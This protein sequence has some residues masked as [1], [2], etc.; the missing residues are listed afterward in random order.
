MAE[1]E[2]ESLAVDYSH[3]WQVMTAVGVAV[4]LGT[5]DGSIVNIAL[6]TI[7]D[8]FGTSFGVIQWVPLSYLLVQATLVLGMGRLGDIAGR[9]TMFITGFAIFTVGSVL[10]GLSPTVLWLI[11][12][13]VVQGI[14]SA[15]IFSM[16]AAL[17]TES[18]PP[19]ERGKALGVNGTIVST[20]II[21]GPI[22]GGLIIDAV[23]WRWIFYVNLPVGIVGILAALRYLPHTKPGSDERFD[24]KGAV[25]FFIGLLT[26]LLGLTLSQDL[27]F[28]D[29]LVISLYVIA[30]IAL[31]SFGAVEQR[32]R[33]PMLD[34]HMFRSRDFSM[35]LFARF[36]TFVAMSGISLIFPFYLTDVLGLAPRGV[37]LAMS[38][39]PVTMGIVAPLA[40]A[41]SDRNGVRKVAMVG[42]VMMVAAFAVTRLVLDADT[43]I[44]LFVAAAFLLG[45]SFGTFQAP[46]N[47]AVMG[48]VPHARLGVASGL[49]TITRIIGWI[50][51]IAVMG[52]IWA[53]RTS[54]YAGGGAAEDAPAT[55]QAAGLSDV[56]VISVGVVAAI[57]LLSWRVWRGRWDAT[58]QAGTRDP[59]SAA[60]GRRGE[61]AL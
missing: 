54:A 59:A 26:L 3:K 23:D 29:P 10:S 39:L 40:G 27:G 48:A 9:K 8:D 4:F 1:P 55:A 12:F 18:F 5:V 60:G 52:T 31:T 24:F 53:V 50:T 30:G 61:R 22:L 17:I 42:L 49:V 33:H 16:T 41:W 14:G 21:S 13:R 15:L 36:V 46:N 19:S 35:S 20:G 45:L 51:G 2:Q 43:P 28:G 25:L 7:V 6:P 37:G 44:W 58:V 38:A 11:I 47:S 34:L 56:L 32:V 57:T